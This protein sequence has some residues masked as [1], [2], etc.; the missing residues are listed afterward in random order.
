MGQ[1]DF[2][3][4]TQLKKGA[5]VCPMNEYDPINAWSNAII[6]RAKTLGWLLLL[7]AF[8]MCLIAPIFGP[9][10]KHMK[11]RQYVMYSDYE[12]RAEADMK[13]IRLLLW[14]IAIIGW[15]FFVYCHV[16]Y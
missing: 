10:I 14:I 9:F 4:L 7:L 11:R 16:V 15:I 2:L 3:R 12:D 8:V 1:M 5:K 6:D 13:S